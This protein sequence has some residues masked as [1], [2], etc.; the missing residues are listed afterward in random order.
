MVLFMKMEQKPLEGTPDAGSGETLEKQQNNVK[1]A[2]KKT[3]IMD[4]HMEKVCGT[5]QNTPFCILV[6]FLYSRIYT[7]M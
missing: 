1:C 5:Y 7:T 2:Q 6:V 4:E 3:Q